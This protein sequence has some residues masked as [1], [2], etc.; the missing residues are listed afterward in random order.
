MAC[1]APA[2][3]PLPAPHKFIDALR[4]TDCP[5]PSPSHV[6]PIGSVSNGFQISKSDLKTG[7]LEN[8]LTFSRGSQPTKG[9]IRIHGA[10]S[11]EVGYI[12]PLPKYTLTGSGNASSIP[13]GPGVTFLTPP[14]RGIPSGRGKSS[15]RVWPGKPVVRSGLRMR[16]GLDSRQMD[17]PIQHHT[18]L[19][20]T[21]DVRQIEQGLL[22]LM[23]DFQAGNLRAFGENLCIGF[24]LRFMLD[25]HTIA[26]DDIVDIKSTLPYYLRTKIYLKVHLFC[27]QVFLII[28]FYL[29]VKVNLGILNQSCKL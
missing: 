9:A 4:Q 18:F 17:R 23:E 3:A 10:H 24:T 2:P 21:A 19:A 14:S 15:S 29:T 16:G 12:K 11:G 20:D 6:V 8:T 27:I 25:T 13:R 5:L 7:D 26:Y 28:V 22:Q 1:P